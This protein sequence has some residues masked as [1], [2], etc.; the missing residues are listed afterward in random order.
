MSELGSHAHSRAPANTYGGGTTLLGGT[1]EL[2]T[3]N[4]LPAGSNLTL[5]GGRLDLNGNSETLGTL[6]ADTA[7]EP[8][9]NNG[10]AATLTINTALNT[11]AN[12]TLDVPLSLGGANTWTVARGTTLTVTGGV[13][14]SGGLN[15]AGAGTVIFS[16]A[17]DDYSGDTAIQNGVL[18]VEPGG[19]LA[20][21]GRGYLG[22]R[23]HQRRPGTGRQLFSGRPNSLPA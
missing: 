21:T 11:N 23:E 5:S 12:M 4:A 19:S 15:K 6:T 3:A 9:I 10:V 18:Q 7:G 16:T 2:A 13:G 20:A 17:G 8:I 1:V 22:Q 14:G